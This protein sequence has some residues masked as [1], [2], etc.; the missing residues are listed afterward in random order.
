MV[1]FSNN[2]DRVLIDYKTLKEI[3]MQ[4]NVINRYR[5]TQFKILNFKI[6]F[7]N[8]KKI[9]NKQKD[10]FLIKENFIRFNKS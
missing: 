7:K 3:C 1:L 10:L 2:N 9:Q 8:L 5:K 4:L 6:Q